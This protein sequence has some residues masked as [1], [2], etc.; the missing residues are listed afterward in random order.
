MKI[1]Y[2]VQR[3]VKGVFPLRS[4]HSIFLFQTA[5]MSESTVLYFFTTVWC[6]IIVDSESTM[7][8]ASLDPEEPVLAPPGSPRVLHDPEVLPALGPEAHRNHSVVVSVLAV[9]IR[10]LLAAPRV[11]EDPIA[12]VKHVAGLQLL[13]LKS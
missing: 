5:V 7:A 4:L 8:C 13:R 6:E 9:G 11:V 2:S 3:S 12:V 10:R 1:E